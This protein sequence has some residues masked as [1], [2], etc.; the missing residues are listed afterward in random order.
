M[1]CA[2]WALTL[3][4]SATPMP[5]D[6]YSVLCGV[7]LNALVFGE[8][9][10]HTAAQDAESELEYVPN[11]KKRGTVVLVPSPSRKMLKSSQSSTLPSSCF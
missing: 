10:K 2:Q 3:D 4:T 11:E 9:S 7:T 5:H 1:L 6:V 8:Q